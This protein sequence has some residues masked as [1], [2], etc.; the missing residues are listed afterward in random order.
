MP[1]SRLLYQHEIAAIKSGHTDLV[2]KPLVLC[3]KKSTESACYSCVD[4]LPNCYLDVSTSWTELVGKLTSEIEFLAI[5]IDTITDHNLSITEWV[6]MMSATCTLMHFVTP[7]TMRVVIKKSTSG[8]IIRQ[9]K[10]TAISGILLDVDEFDI[11]AITFAMDQ[12]LAKIPHWPKHIIDNLPGNKKTVPYFTNKTTITL[13]PR[14]QQVLEL[15]CNRGLSNRQIGDML[16]I[17]EHTVKIHVSGIMRA[18]GVKTRTQLAV[19][20]KQL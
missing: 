2:A 10:K 3:L 9:L 20:V 15:I 14:Q 7:L 16:S 19:L 17:S 18:Y 11:D 12:T 1:L 13:T 6:N 5:H 8:S 4:L